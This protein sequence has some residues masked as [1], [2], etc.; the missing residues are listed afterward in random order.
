[1]NEFALALQ[2]VKA[3]IDIVKGFGSLK[4]MI[5]VNEKA[6]ELFNIINSLNSQIASL[7][8][9]YDEIK[10]S[11]VELNKK[12][13]ALTEWNSNKPK[14]IRK[15]LP[16]GSSAY[17]EKEN[18]NSPINVNWYCQNCFD[19]LQKISVYQPSE[20][21]NPNI[22][23][24]DY[25]CPNCASKIIVPNPDFIKPSLDNLDSEEDNRYKF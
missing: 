5:A 10:D 2:S 24:N 7:R 25:L 1:M 14:Y 13:L 19:N 22:S 11:Y 15:K 8:T 16:T 18:G 20:I 17:T 12:Y 4:S 23:A 6:A 21:R 3:A 9:Q